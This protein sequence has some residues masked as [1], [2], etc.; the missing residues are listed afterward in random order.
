MSG[1]AY[2]EKRGPNLGNRTIARHATQAGATS[3][4]LMGILQATVEKGWL[5]QSE[6]FLALG[7]IPPIL[8]SI[9]KTWDGLRMQ[10]RVN[11]K[12]DKMMPP[13]L[14]LLVIL[15]C[16][17]CA[18]QL[19]KMQPKSFTSLDG[20]MLIACDTQGIL[21]TVGDSDICSNSMRGG[22]VSSTFSDMT[23]GVVRVAG[24]AVAG[25]FGGAGQGMAQAIRADEAQAQVVAP[26][27]PPAVEPAP[28][29]PSWP[30]NP[31]TPAE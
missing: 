26:S 10:D 21:F 13:S 3:V 25:F 20:T 19:G 9:W 16:S 5:D 27:A 14:F 2:D 8:T 7:L 4:G 11:A 31:F 1:P 30:A 18:V 6:A 15:L 29:E 12:L 24:A 28:V 17:G 22:R 23:L